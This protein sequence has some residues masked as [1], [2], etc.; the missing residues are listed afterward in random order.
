LRAQS[1]V[2]ELPIC[3]D[4]YQYP[5]SLDVIQALPL[6]ILNIPA[7]LTVSQPPVPDLVI[8]QEAP[9]QVYLYE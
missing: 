7:T 5:A 2:D 9:L 6:N 1:S 3:L 8:L 4:V